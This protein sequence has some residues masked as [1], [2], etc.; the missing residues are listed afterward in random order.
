MFQ[1]QLSG[2]VGRNVRLAVAVFDAIV[3]VSIL[4]AIPEFFNSIPAEAAVAGSGLG[5][6]VMQA[7]LTLMA[8]SAVLSGT[9]IGMLLG[10]PDGV[11]M[12]GRYQARAVLSL[13]SGLC[14]A[15]GLAVALLCTRTPMGNAAFLG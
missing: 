11:R 2:N 4:L 14:L 1:A 13:A 9:S 15:L 12:W 3:T 7:S 10:D 5:I 8:I 6:L